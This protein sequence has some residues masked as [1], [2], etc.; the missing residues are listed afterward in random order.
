MPRVQI[1]TSQATWFVP[2]WHSYFLNNHRNQAVLST[3]QDEE[4]AFLLAVSGGHKELV[5]WLTDEVMVD[6]HY[7][8][9][10]SLLYE[11]V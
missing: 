9:A 5:V 7:S 1:H 2:A 3:L 6:V 10:V 11:S 8:N 4:N